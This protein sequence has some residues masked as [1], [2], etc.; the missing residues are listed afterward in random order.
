MC[1][2]C[3]SSECA[4][5]HFQPSFPIS[6]VASQELR[7]MLSLLAS[8]LHAAPSDDFPETTRLFED[9]D[10]CYASLCVYFDVRRDFQTNPSLRL[11]P[12]LVEDVFS[13]V[14]ESIERRLFVRIS[15]AIETVFS[16]FL[17][18]YVDNSVSSLDYADVATVWLGMS[19]SVLF[20][21]DGCVCVASLICRLCL[22]QQYYNEIGRQIGVDLVSSFLHTTSVGFVLC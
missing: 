19:N 18:P 7:A 1:V 9:L 2:E 5:C 11:G 22:L 12:P 20:C 17:M 6:V 14:R 21:F 13:T 16:S 4:N 3:R 15:V 8:F 10:D